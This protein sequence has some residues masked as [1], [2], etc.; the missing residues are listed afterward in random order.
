MSLNRPVF[1]IKIDRDSGEVWL[2]E[3]A[4]LYAQEAELRDTYF[5]DNIEDGEEL[6]VKIRFHHKGC[7]AVVHKKTSSFHVRFLEPQKAVTPGQSAV[8]YRGRQLVGG[9]LL[10]K[11]TH[12]NQTRPYRN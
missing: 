6:K 1:V 11:G 7:R 12:K 2:G 4:H 10:G 9:V 3:E 8:F 5:L